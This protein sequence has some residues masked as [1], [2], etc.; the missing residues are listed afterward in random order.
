M[1]K[2]KKNLDDSNL[3]AAA[4]FEADGK[5]RNRDGGQRS[6]QS[7][8]EKGSKVERDRRR[9]GYDIY[10]GEDDS[11][12]MYD[13]K[14]PDSELMDLDELPDYDYK[15]SKDRR[16]P[17]GGGGYLTDDRYRGGGRDGRGQ[18]PSRVSPP[19]YRT[20]GGGYYSDDSR[21][22]DYLERRADRRRAP[23]LRRA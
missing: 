13:A 10:A 12:V 23:P 3:V 22:S 17:R 20:D 19:R 9:R 14:T 5:R 2:K 1:N 8:A 11:N 4:Q 6:R 18:E 7:G 15:R 16:R 21:Y